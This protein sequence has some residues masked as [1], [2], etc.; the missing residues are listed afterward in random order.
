MFRSVRIRRRKYGI[1]E[2]IDSVGPLRSAHVC[3]EFRNGK[4]DEPMK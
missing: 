2:S 4:H 1:D 3:Y